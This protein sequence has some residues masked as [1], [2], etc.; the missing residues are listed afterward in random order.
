M[1]QRTSED[2]L[3][4]CCSFRPIKSKPKL[5]GPGPMRVL[6]MIWLLG[7]AGI[8]PSTPTTVSPSPRAWREGS[9]VVT[10]SSPG[11][12]GTTCLP[13]ARIWLKV[14]WLWSHFVNKIGFYW[15][16]S[17]RTSSIILSDKVAGCF[18]SNNKFIDFGHIMSVFGFPFFVRA[19][20]FLHKYPKKCYLILIYLQFL[21]IHQN[22]SLLSILIF[23]NSLSYRMSENQ[24][25]R[26]AQHRPGYRE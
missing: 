6:W 13:T 19:L 11:Q 4:C 17:N 18:W 10:T 21:L 15:L 1:P 5:V 8:P 9:E 26:E 2:P 14:Y 20:F 12:S 24:S 23:Y 22:L 16:I 25:R 3:G 7:S